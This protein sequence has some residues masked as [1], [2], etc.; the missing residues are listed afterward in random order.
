MQSLR[1]LYPQPLLAS[2]PWLGAFGSWPLGSCVHGRSA[3][4]V[5]CQCHLPTA[6]IEGLHSEL[7]ETQRR[8]KPSAIKML[9]CLPQPFFGASFFTSPK[10]QPIPVTMGTCHLSFSWLNNNGQQTR[11]VLMNDNLSLLLTMDNA[12]EPNM[13]HGTQHRARTQYTAASRSG[14]PQP[15]GQGPVLVGGLLGP[16]PHSRR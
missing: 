14:V 8:A 3:Q 16:G 10:L 5:S 9:P 6:G 1:F 7:A 2:F 13:Q 12:T 4:L 11:K 15:P